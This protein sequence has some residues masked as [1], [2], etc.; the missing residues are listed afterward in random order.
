MDQGLSLLEA[1][2]KYEEEIA[3]AKRQAE[4]K[5]AKGLSDDEVHKLWGEHN[6]SRQIAERK[7]SKVQRF[8]D[9][10]ARAEQELRNSADRLADI[11]LQLDSEMERRR[12][13][14][15]KDP[16]SAVPAE[17]S[18]DKATVLSACDLDALDATQRQEAED[19][20]L[21]ITQAKERAAAENSEAEKAE[22]VLAERIA[23]I[24]K[25]KRARPREHSH[26]ETGS[27]G[28]GGL[29]E[30]KKP[31]EGS[32]AEKPLDKSIDTSAAFAKNPRISR[33][34]NAT[35]ASSM[36][37]DAAESE[38]NEFDT[39]DE[40]THDESAGGRGRGSNPSRS[41]IKQKNEQKAQ[42]ILNDAISRSFQ[43]AVERVQQAKTAVE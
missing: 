22:A 27:N 31:G 5:K 21:R 8:T 42:D 32:D 39:A 19:L 11:K 3:A 15:K 1:N 6:K 35:A 18:H 25:E 4:E 16:S 34:S 41:A 9:G 2:S 13:D 23:Q 30:A 14:G 43:A 40:E 24:R 36:Q 29:L 20:M 12:Q 28:V 26:E 37:V 38:L 7:A 17:N 33:S 10:L